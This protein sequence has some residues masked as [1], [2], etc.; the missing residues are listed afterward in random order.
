MFE[1]ISYVHPH[2]I[3]LQI[4]LQFGMFLGS[5]LSVILLAKLYLTSRYQNL[6]IY[7]MYNILVIYTLTY[8]LF[9]SNYLISNFFWILILTLTTASHGTKNFKNTY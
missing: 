9:S 8:L 3:F 4:I 7:D 1:Y 6:F 2:N 5:I